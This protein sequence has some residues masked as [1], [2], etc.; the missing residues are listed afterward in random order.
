MPQER[1]S[2][3]EGEMQNSAVASHSFSKSIGARAAVYETMLGALICRMHSI[4]LETY[5][6]R[7]LRGLTKML[8]DPEAADRSA[9]GMVL[10]TSSRF[11]IGKLRRDAG[12]LAKGREVTAENMQ[13]LRIFVSRMFL[14]AVAELDES[15]CHFD[16]TDFGET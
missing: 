2:G 3:Q 1:L 14:C 11:D 10:P 6:W 15:T 8:S 5:Q 4:S 9:I 13:T 12:E 16:D 7:C